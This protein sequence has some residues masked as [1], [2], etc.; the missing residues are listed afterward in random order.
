MIQT[1]SVFNCWLYEWPCF[2]MRTVRMSPVNIIQSMRSC[3]IWFRLLLSFF[4]P[5]LSYNE[6]VWGMNGPCKQGSGVKLHFKSSVYQLVCHLSFAV[7]RPLYSPCTLGSN[8]NIADDCN[9]LHPCMSKQLSEQNH[10]DRW[11]V[12]Q[13]RV[14]ETVLCNSMVSHYHSQ[15]VVLH[16][17]DEGQSLSSLSSLA[18]SRLLF[19]FPPPVSRAR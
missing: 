8:P 5:F 3:E 13:N 17:L 18:E 9:C 4:F 1:C 10:K 15:V 12:N 6:F 16:E 19:V 2:E 14:P 7:S 11:I